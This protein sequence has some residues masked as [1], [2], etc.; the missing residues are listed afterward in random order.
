MKKNFAIVLSIFLL[1]IGVVKAQSGPDAVKDL[2]AKRYQTAKAAFEKLLAANPNDIE[3]TY[4]LGQTL[5]EMNDVPAA[6]ALYEKAL[7]ASAN[8]PLVIVGMG[9]V[10]LIQN[11]I[12][13]ARQRFEAAITMTSGKKGGDPQI[14]NAVGRAIANV[15]TDKEKK[16][17][18]NY[19]IEKLKE[20]SL[21]KTKD[22]A[23]LADIYV[24]LGNAYRKARPGEGGGDAYQNYQKAI[25][26]KPDF[27]VPYYK[28]A[29]L[30]NTQHNWD[31]YQ[32]YLEK[33]IEKDPK[34]APAYYDLY[35]Y[36]LGKLDFN[37][38]EIYAKKFMENS[39]PDPQNDYLRVQTLYAK[40][41]Y[42]QA[43]AGA[44]AIA[45]KAG[46]ATKPIVYK[47]LAYSHVEKGDTLQARQY[48]DN[49]FAKATDED[50]IPK[51]YTLKAIIYSVIP[52]QEAI[53][54]KS[55]IDGVKADTSLENKITLLKDGIKF[56]NDKKKYAEEAQLWDTLLVIKPPADMKIN[57][58]FGPT[59]A[60]Y[61]DSSYAR[62][63]EFAKQMADKYP[64]QQFGWEWMF[65]NSQILDTVKRD[66]IAIPDAMNLL[67]FTK[68]D[69]VK[70]G[71]QIKGASYLIA[72]YYS[73]KK[74]LDSAIKYLKL[75]KSA[76]VETAVKESIQQN[77]K[78]LEEAL[79]QQKKSKSSAGSTSPAKKPEG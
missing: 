76:T 62:S 22:V 36:K 23:L 64:D 77:I 57:D 28:M 55:Y 20:A 38:A 65:N 63:R 39:D 60:N 61:R 40:K 16:G 52:G 79:A 78:T 8:A 11:K 2:Y 47:L 75:M 25:D 43:I 66:S 68:N 37:G 1:T 59:L 3:A 48:I 31:L 4:W 19:A 10:E 45:S 35:Y 32:Q 70:Y 69:T 50:I 30:F 71:R 12:N 56:F 9:Q 74:E 42:D 58:L 17:D 6:R 15:Y 41:Q 33:A 14:L 46:T 26:T 72:I 73:Q 7:L 27:A 18:I 34:F 29:G 5:I 67:A 53:V 54:V 24:N 13:E 44:N 49:Y 51:D 21:I